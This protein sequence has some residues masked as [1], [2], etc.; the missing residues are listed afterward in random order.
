[1]NDQNNRQPSVLS[2]GEKFV[3][4]NLLSKIGT[5]FVIASVI[6]FSAAS[7][8]RIPDIVRLIL[9]LAVGLIMLAAGE[10][11]RRKGSEIFANTMVYGGVAEL[12]ICAPIGRFGLEIFDDFGMLVYSTIA[13]ALGFGLAWRYRS[14]GLT[15]VV[16]AAS[17]IPS[18]SAVIENE[19]S[20]ASVFVTLPVFLMFTH[21][22]NAVISRKLRFDGAFITGICKAVTDVFFVIAYASGY[23]DDW[24]YE[25][26][27]FES[28]AEEV[29]NGV[30][31]LADFPYIAP[32]LFAVIFLIC[33]MVC[34]SAGALLNAAEDDGEIKAIDCAGL[35]MPQGIVIFFVW[36]IFGLTSHDK[37]LG[38]ILLVLALIYSLIIA[39]FTLKF[40]KYCKTNTALT[41]LILVCVEIALFALF[42]TGNWEYMALHSFA[43]AVLLAGFF[44]ERKLLKGWGWGLLAIAEIRFL[45]V[46]VESRG[47]PEGFKLSAAI[48]NMILWFGIMAVLGTLKKPRE[49]IGFRLY[50]F[51]ALLNAGLVCS[52]LISD[53]LMKMFRHSDAFHDKAQQ[54]AFSGLLCAAVWM[55]LGFIAGKL[56]YL[57]KWKAPVSIT[58]Y[59]IGFCCLGWANFA[60]MFSNS[61]N[62]EL[63]TMLVIATVIVNVVSVPAV[64]DITLQIQEKA[65]KFSRAV[66]LIVSGYAMM[67]LT[68][69]LGTNN[70]V[71]FTSCIISILY[72][73]LAAAWIIIGFW[74]NNPFL[75]RFGLALALFS[76]AKLFLFD[77]RGVD[78]F[79]RTL[80]FIGFGITLLGISFGY[81]I[82]EKRLSR[83]EKENEPVD[84]SNEK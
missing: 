50:S 35:C 20:Q 64:L 44:F 13:A 34:Y 82:M 80:L 72:L 8:G 12:M 45:A 77:F 9:I 71:K 30:Q 59:A 79:G 74:K 31:R 43:A 28:A 33:C 38:V 39:A 57:K 60:N 25:N 53:D 22:A 47:M 52:N 61:R 4:I 69:I 7:E 42:D 18:F 5:V 24:V 56:P 17:L 6:A 51:G 76:S 40:W 37:L 41:N 10:L 16:T 48:V 29:P 15:I 26:H 73:A 23:V 14:Q 68:T 46:L 36:V 84:K 3:A 65:S 63:G 49:S 21:F 75:R 58:H 19:Y 27:V 2:G 78:A 70:T 54:S 67:S 81:A 66:G 62:I 32:D 83:S 55:I 11:F 1:M